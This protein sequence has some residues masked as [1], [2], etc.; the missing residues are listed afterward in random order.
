[1]ENEQWG[2]SIE[3]NFPAE[4]AGLMECKSFR[5]LHNSTNRW[6]NSHLASRVAHYAF[7]SVIFF[8]AGRR[9][10]SSGD[11]CFRC[12][13]RGHWAENC[14][15]FNNNAASRP[16]LHTSMSENSTRGR[17]APG[18]GFKGRCSST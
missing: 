7:L 6:I 9:F 2:H 1:M 8:L 17:D 14:F 18:Q 3:M 11:L 4:V 13:K 10:F 12:G 15:K 5:N 16:I